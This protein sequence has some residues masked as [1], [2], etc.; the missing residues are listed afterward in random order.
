[1][2]FLNQQSAHTAVDPLRSQ[3][4]P[5]ERPSLRG[6]VAMAAGV[7]A[8]GLGLAT[9]LLGLS[10]G[11]R[12]EAPPSPGVAPSAETALHSYGGS[13]DHDWRYVVNAGG[14]CRLDPRYLPHT[15][16]AVE[17]WF[18]SCDARRADPNGECRFDP[19]YL[20]H[21]PDAVEGWYAQLPRQ[22]WRQVGLVGQ[23]LGGCPSSGIDQAL[24]ERASGT[25][26]QVR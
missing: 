24:T 23:V 6:R 16:D 11:A 25:T 4:V 19:R 13:L 15:P 3:T 5:A 18:A 7:A 22:N 1:M 21:T 9:L 10:A 20:P 2:N 8:S 14:D 17:G 26:G 12:A